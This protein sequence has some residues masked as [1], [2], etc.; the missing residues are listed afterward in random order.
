MY[1]RKWWQGCDGI[2]SKRLAD[3]ALNDD[4]IRSK[5][6]MQIFLKGFEWIH[7]AQYLLFALIYELE[8]QAIDALKSKLSL[9]I[10]TIGPNI[11]YFSLTKNYP[12]SNNTNHSYYFKW[13]DLQPIGSVL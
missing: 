11:P 12:K 6:M 1:D 4:S 9:P 8:S 5:R 2:G 13:L 3:F 10:Y 7:K